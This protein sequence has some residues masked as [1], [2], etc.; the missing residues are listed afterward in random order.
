MTPS[1][2]GERGAWSPRRCG[3]ADWFGGLAG[4]GLARDDRMQLPIEEGGTGE[5]ITL[6]EDPSTAPIT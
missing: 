5:P 1:A 4:D 3:E 2:N 6:S